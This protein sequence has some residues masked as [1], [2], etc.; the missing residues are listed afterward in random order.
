[1]FKNLKTLLS[2]RSWLKSRTLNLAAVLGAI[3]TLDVTSGTGM[4]QA[5]IDFMS[6]TFGLMEPTSVALLLALKSLADVVLRV[7]TDKS[8]ADK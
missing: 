6:N 2:L 1:M 5:A 7:K 4:V 3:A 8:L